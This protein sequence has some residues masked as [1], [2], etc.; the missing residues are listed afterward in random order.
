MV[1]VNCATGTLAPY[2][3]SAAMPWNRQRALHLYRRL[4][5]GAT[6]QEVEAALAQN[7]VALVD[8]LI[9]AAIALPPTP[10]P[11]WA[12]WDI[13][14]Y[15][16][17]GQQTQEQLIAYVT[18][19]VK[20]MIANGLR[21]KMALFWSNHLVARYET[22]VC[23]SYLYQYHTLLQTHALGNYKTFVY[24]MGKTPAMLIFLNGVQNTLFSPNENYARELYELFTLGQDNGYTQ[25]DIVNT[26]RA[27]TGWNGF[28]VA[29]AP[30]PYVPFL[31]D[32]GNK[33]IFGQ[34]GNWGYDE[35]HNILFTQRDDEIAHHICA[36]LYRTFVHP[37]V[38]EEI[39]AELATTFKNNNWELA[40]VL[41][42]LFRSEHFFDEFVIGAE[43]KSPTELML[44]LIRESGNTFNDEI[45]EVS[46]YLI[47]NLG[48]ELF[49]PTDVAGWPGNR[50][51]IDS[52]SLTGRWLAC[53][54]YLYGM[55]ENF[56][57]VLVNLAKTLS[58]NS[59]DPEVVARAIAD[60][61]TPNGLYSDEAYVRAVA[62]FKWEVPQ[63]YYDNGLWNLDWPT[64]PAQTALLL[65]NLSRLPEF[66][67]M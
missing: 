52:S 21:E 14:D 60:F 25:E 66:Q 53:D 10:P 12:D 49:N 56:P 59:T 48:Q 50:E 16:D 18:D 57:Q 4:G 44:N 55:Y 51:W 46:T 64:A 65:R 37:E 61:Y 15:T 58:G 8:S 54:A 23:P 31:H 34:T 6:P 40:P 13:N 67:L 17:F 62:A 35:V 43:V 30:I 20:D 28:T 2:V 7:P 42:Q 26:A 47:Y 45:I 29:C 9:D 5:F 11:V 41:R 39:V 1:T 33:T 22:Y 24:E 27:L 19:W 63:N 36:K 32:N 38:K 3:P